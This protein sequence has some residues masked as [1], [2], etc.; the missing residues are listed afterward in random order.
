MKKILTFLLIMLLIG[1]AAG[2]AT[3]ISPT[4]QINWS[5][6]IN[7]QLHGVLAGSALDDVAIVSQLGG[8]NSVYA[9]NYGVTADDATDDTTAMNLAIAAANGTTFQ[10]GKD[11]IMPPGIVKIT[12]GGLSPLACSIIGP[13]TAVSATGTSG[14]SVFT[15]AG[16]AMSK[17]IDLWRI[18][19]TGTNMAGLTYPL[20]H[21]PRAGSAISMGQHGDCVYNRVRVG[22]IEG[23]TNGIYMDGETRGSHIASNTIDI[24]AL[25]NNTMGV[26]AVSKKYQVE[27]NNIHI[28]YSAFNNATIFFVQ[29]A[30]PTAGYPYGIGQNVVEIDAIELFNITDQIGI[31]AA[32]NRTLQNEFILHDMIVTSPALYIV[33]AQ[34]NAINNVATLSEAGDSSGSFARIEWRDNILKSFGA[35]I[36]TGLTSFGRSEIWATSKPTTGNWTVGTIVHH[37]D[38]AINEPSGWV[39]T[40]APLTFGKLANLTAA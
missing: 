26:N 17:T 21:Y 36:S 28:G 16:S 25:I 3:R 40:T 7:S 8:N 12:V 1:G 13:N 22:Y 29:S 32:G 11:I 19:A 6:D 9:I 39:C 10:N 4:T 30:T 33:C 37:S 24:N 31:Y 18:S 14:A 38:A 35:G 5:K 15:M 34:A 27:N 2:A 20:D 23:F